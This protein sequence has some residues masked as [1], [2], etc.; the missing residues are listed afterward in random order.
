[1]RLMF[2]SRTLPIWQTIVGNEYIYG[3]ISKKIGFKKVISRFDGV[4]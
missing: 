1:M 3:K 2:S 4:F